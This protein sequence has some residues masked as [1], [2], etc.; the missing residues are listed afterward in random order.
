MIRVK[1]LPA[2]TFLLVMVFC[3]SSLA[4]SSGA[5]TDSLIERYETLKKT[6]REKM[7]EVNS[8]DAYKAVMKERTENLE[9]ILKEFEGKELTDPQL[10]L[11]GKVL[12]DL[13][14]YDDALPKFEELIQKK[15]KLILDAKVHKVRVLLQKNKAEEA[16]ALFDAISGKLDKNKDYF[17]LLSDM[18]Y[19]AKDPDKQ[20]AYAL[21]FIKEA[22]DDP[23]LTSIKGYMYQKIAEIE[24][25]KGNLNKAIEIM[26]NAAASVKDD[27]LKGRLENTLK[28]YK[29][30]GKPA[31]EIESK[32]WFNSDP[33]TL[34]G[35]KGSV[36]IVDFW[37][38]WCGPCRYVI[39]TLVE[40]YNEFKDK[41]LVVIGFTRVQGSYNDEK[42]QKGK[43][44]LEEEVKLTEEF[45]KRWKMNYPVAM[46]DGR[47]TFN[48]YFVRG[49]PTMAVIDRKGNLHELE[50]G[51]GDLKELKERIKGFVEKK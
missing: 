5:D 43:V 27:R 1:R 31:P 30:I 9:S 39:P 12:L 40:A 19:A 17:S 38:T 7:K 44:P 26:E 21:K 24:K 15:S 48:A 20:A 50:V 22:G 33:L 25:Q 46:A 10:L 2:I 37:A 34:A 28:Q 41:G 6:I 32:R 16:V 11:Q 3:V 29:L 42:Y 49:I 13:R 51:A 14:K 36:V 47:D 8:R 4:F 23:E 18:P 45:V 35:L